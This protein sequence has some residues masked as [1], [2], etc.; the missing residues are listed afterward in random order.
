[1]NVSLQAC[2]SVCGVK[3]YE[4]WIRPSTCSIPDYCRQPNVP[5]TWRTGKWSPTIVATS[6]V[7]SRSIGD[8][9][10]L[11]SVKEN[12]A[13]WT[14]SEYSI[15][16]RH[17]VSSTNVI[18]HAHYFVVRVLAHF[19]G[20][21]V[22]VFLFV[23]LIMGLRLQKASF[24]FYGRLK[25]DNICQTNWLQLHSSDGI[26]HKTDYA[27]LYWNTSTAYKENYNWT[28]SFQFRIGCYEL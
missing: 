13:V 14:A 10:P 27:F 9:S 25:P 16:C 8:S 1:M 11:R 26:F 22:E 20:L 15:D 21:Y 4:L 5:G 12:F 7:D 2:R 24:E 3:W 19:V 23:H 18:R 6:L 28:N 17:L